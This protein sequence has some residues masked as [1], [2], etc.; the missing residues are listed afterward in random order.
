[1][2]A[3]PARGA[4]GGPAPQRRDTGA[5]TAR[6]GQSSGASAGGVRTPLIIKMPGK[7]YQGM[8]VDDLVSYLDYLPTIIS[9]VGGTPQE[10]LPGR[11][12]LAVLQGRSI[13]ENAF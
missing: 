10:G 13:D 12:L 5:L 6:N 2:A 3:S 9:F 11:D 4:A 1:M 8:L 7:Q